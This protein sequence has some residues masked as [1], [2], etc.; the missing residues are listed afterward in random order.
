MPG[1]NTSENIVL[2][3]GAGS[4]GGARGRKATGA[5]CGTAR[6]TGASDLPHIVHQ[7]HKASRRPHTLLHGMRH[8]ADVPAPATSCPGSVANL[9]RST[10]RAPAATAGRVIERQ[11]NDPGG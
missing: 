7:T 2:L 6:V 1:A 8:Q 9:A 3:V 4:D 11:A 10:T 5:K